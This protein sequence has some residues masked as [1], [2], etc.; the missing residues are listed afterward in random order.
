MLMAQV[1]RD[2]PKVLEEFR[3][4]MTGSSEV[5]EISNAG[6]LTEALQDT[7]L[8]PFNMPIE[9]LLQRKSSE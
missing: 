2:A 9:F 4:K 8:N 7:S 5:T 3:S 6:K 1:E